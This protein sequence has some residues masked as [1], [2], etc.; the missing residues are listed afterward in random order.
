MDRDFMTALKPFE[1]AWP[2]GQRADSR[3]FMYFLDLCRV[4]MVLP[5]EM[6]SG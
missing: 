3:A 1:R 6:G 2:K 5:H 4:H